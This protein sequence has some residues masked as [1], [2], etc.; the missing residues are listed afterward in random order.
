M[1]GGIC[2]ETQHVPNSINFDLSLAPILKANQTV[3]SRTV[4]HYK[5][6]EKYGNQSI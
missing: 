5:K 1:N 6:G 4:Y 3:T 2:F